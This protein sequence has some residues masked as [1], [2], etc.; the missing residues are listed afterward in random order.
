MKT[1]YRM[2]LAVAATI[3]FL[4]TSSWADPVPLPCEPHCTVDPCKLAPERC[5]KGGGP[6]GA[7][8]EYDKA[9]SDN[10]NH[11]KKATAVESTNK[12]NEDDSCSF[13]VCDRGTVKPSCTSCCNQKK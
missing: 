4:S 7:E 1:I 5:K 2:T 13:C 3:L 12:Q 9:A 8:A 6:I 10:Q 11:A